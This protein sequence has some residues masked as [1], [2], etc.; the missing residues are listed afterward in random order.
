MHFCLQIP[1]CNNASHVCQPGYLR[2]CSHACIS[3]CVRVSLG[4][5]PDCYEVSF[6]AGG[7]S[8]HR[9]NQPST[10]TNTHMARGGGPALLMPAGR[11]D[12]EDKLIRWRLGET[13]KQRLIMIDGGKQ[14]V[15]QGE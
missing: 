15:R 5:S 3:V 9:A 6:T 12:R 11:P 8:G 13:W 7:R 4:S 1:V 14:G 2:V 10:D